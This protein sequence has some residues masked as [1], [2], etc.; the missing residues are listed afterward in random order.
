[1][2]VTVTPG[3]ATLLR[4]GKNIGP[5]P[6]VLHLGDGETA[7]LSITRKGYKPKSVVIDGRDP[8]VSFSLDPEKAAASAAAKPA[9]GGGGQKFGGVIDDS[10]PFAHH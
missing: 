1:V 9:A 5:Q 4:D 2:L 6:V 3:D 10:D 8:R 7:S